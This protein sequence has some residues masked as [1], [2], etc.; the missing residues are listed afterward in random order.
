MPYLWE[1]LIIYYKVDLKNKPTCGSFSV[2]AQLTYGESIE[3]YLKTIYELTN[4]DDLVP[5]SVLA[6]R[7]GISAVSATE[8]VHRLRENNLVKHERYRGI[9]LTE[10]GYRQALLVVRRH[11]LWERFLVDTLH[12]PWEEA[13]DLACQ[14]EHMTKQEVIDALADFLEN[15]LS[16]PH[17][18]PIPGTD[19]SMK[20]QTGIPLDT[21]VPGQGGEVLCIHPESHAALLYFSSRRIKPGVHIKMISNN[22]FDQLWTVRVG[23]REEVLC[24][25]MISRVVIQ[26]VANP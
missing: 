8:M 21:L 20:S 15:P 11:R 26:P 9:R 13:H 7:L 4:A 12:L 18:N 17:G 3:M 16:C 1:T 2:S 25:A 14:L 23:D 19:G 6:E 24:Q 5:I 22:E 10:D